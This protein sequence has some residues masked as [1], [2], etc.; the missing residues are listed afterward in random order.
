LLDFV[1]TD[2]L[3]LRGASYIALV[4]ILL[5]LVVALALVIFFLSPRAPELSFPPPSGL[6]VSLSPFKL[7]L[8]VNLLVVVLVFPC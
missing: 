2:W 5:V 6:A 3:A 4:V 1:I 8:Q 7:S